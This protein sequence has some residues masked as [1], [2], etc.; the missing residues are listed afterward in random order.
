MY[1]KC[2]CA[3]RLLFSYECMFK[4]VS[5]CVCVYGEL[6]VRARL[7]PAHLSHTHSSTLRLD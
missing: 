2:M 4:C 6:G 7:R 5:V 3:D 1:S